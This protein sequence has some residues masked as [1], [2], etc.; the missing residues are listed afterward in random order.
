D[1]HLPGGRGADS[2]DHDRASCRGGGARGARTGARREGAGGFAG[3]G[4]P[5]R[6]G[7]RHG[8]HARGGVDWHRRAAHPRGTPRVQVVAPADRRFRRAHVKPA[9]RKSWVVMAAR[10]LRLVATVAVVSGGGFYVMR[11]AT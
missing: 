6:A 5:S 3:G 1:R 11:L 2:R 7:R 4:G 8:H 9:R 10:T